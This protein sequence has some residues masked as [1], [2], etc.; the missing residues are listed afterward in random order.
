MMFDVIVMN[1]HS[2]LRVNRRIY[3]KVHFHTAVVLLISMNQV[4]NHMN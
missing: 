2:G 4:L 1:T 3:V